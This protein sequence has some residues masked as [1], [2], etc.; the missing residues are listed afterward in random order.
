MASITQIRVKGR[1]VGIVG[2]EESLED[3]SRENL[4]Y[5]DAKRFLLERIRRKNYVPA[6]LE[7]EYGEALANLYCQRRGLPLPE[8]PS[9][10]A[11]SLTIRILGPG[12]ASCQRLEQEVMTAL[13]ELDLP[14]DLL[15]VT[16]IKEIASYGV[17]GTP[18]LVINGEVVSVG[19]I[20]SRA[21]MKEI[22]LEQKGMGR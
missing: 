1:S 21:K 11:P 18:A 20:P 13:M 7:Q 2:L 6:G 9:G 22:I 3:A 10:E 4:G 15:H 16:D 17:M 12:C 5:E 8:N 14:A 19:S